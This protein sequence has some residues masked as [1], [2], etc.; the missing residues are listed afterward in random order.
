[1]AVTFPLS[2][3]N[4][5]DLIR[6]RTSEIRLMPQQQIGVQGSGGAIAKDLAGARWEAD[7]ETTYLNRH[8]ARTVEA[9][10]NKLVGSIGSFLLWDT[11]AWYPLNDPRGTILG[12]TTVQI[13]GSTATGFSLKSAPAGYA[14][15]AGDRFSL[16]STVGTPSAYAYYELAEDATAD[17]SGNVATVVT[18]PYP[19]PS[20]Y[21]TNDNLTFAKPVILALIVP[22]SISYQ[23]GNLGKISFRAQQIFRVPT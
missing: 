6:V 3:A 21:Q 14:F 17:G 4:F 23:P 16:I 22:S 13:A 1:M 10:I 20:T 11:R 5:L 12:A 19:L 8:Q 9:H 15:K 18:N 7:V 2:T